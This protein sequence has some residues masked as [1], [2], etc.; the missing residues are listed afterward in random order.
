MQ[1]SNHTAKERGSLSLVN[2][3][4]GLRKATIWVGTGGIE[5]LHR[6]ADCSLLRDD[7]QIPHWAVLAWSTYI[8]HTPPAWCPG[9]CI[10]SSKQKI[11]RSLGR[12]DKLGKVPGQADHPGGRTLPLPFRGSQ[13]GSAHQR[14]AGETT[15]ALNSEAFPEGLLRL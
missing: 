1:K 2:S 7:K 10:E 15:D 3:Q 9:H 14:L 13:K 6:N 5:G 11:C 12:Q 8:H 4:S